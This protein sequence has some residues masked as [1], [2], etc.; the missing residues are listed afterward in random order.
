MLLHY[1]I[2]SHYIELPNKY[3]ELNQTKSIVRVYKLGSNVPYSFYTDAH[4][5]YGAIIKQEKL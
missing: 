3:L 5:L 4:P 2:I 1:S